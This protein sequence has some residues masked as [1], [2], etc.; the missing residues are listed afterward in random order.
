MTAFHNCV[1]KIESSWAW[2]SPFYKL[3]MLIYI[4][5]ICTPCISWNKVLIWSLR[6][7]WY[8]N[9]NCAPL[10]MKIG[11]ALEILLSWPRG[12]PLPM[13]VTCFGEPSVTASWK[14][15][16][17]FCYIIVFIPTYLLF[18]PAISC[19]LKTLEI[20]AEDLWIR[21]NFLYEVRCR[22]N[23]HLEKLA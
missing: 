1:L 12:T 2:F 9:F 8:L 13:Q 17:L 10:I 6:N 18:L 21:A 15:I 3:E 22:K 16:N 20:C 7:Y 19:W 4:L 5:Y 11:Q 14:N 23:T